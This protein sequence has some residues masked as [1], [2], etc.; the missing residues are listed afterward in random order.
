MQISD[1]TLIE[2]IIVELGFTLTKVLSKKHKN[3]ISKVDI[4]VCEIIIK[5]SFHLH[6]RRMIDSRFLSTLCS[7]P[8][9]STGSAK[10]S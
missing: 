10:K 5:K 4:R 8:L 3:S 1:N 7:F 9:F 6:T 2:N